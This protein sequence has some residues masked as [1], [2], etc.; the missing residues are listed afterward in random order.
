MN[1]DSHT[2]RFK[3]TP[4]GVKTAK[5]LQVES[6][7]GRTLEEDFEKY[8][9]QEQWGQKRLANRWGVKRELIFPLA[10]VEDEDRG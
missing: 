1:V 5:M 6:K 4:A 9:V 10:C 3:A 2:G 8:Y 7:L